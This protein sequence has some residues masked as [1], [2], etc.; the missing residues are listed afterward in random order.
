MIVAV[1]YDILLFVPMSSAV[2]AILLPYVDGSKSLT[3]WL[4]VSV[5]S[6]V[7]IILLK[8]FG[9]RERLLM[10]N[11]LITLTAVVIFYHPAGERVDFLLKHIWTIKDIGIAV[12]SALVFLLS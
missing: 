5:L 6:A 7:F 1:I 9:R 10:I 4:T 3:A 11:A 12:L 2:S 8:N